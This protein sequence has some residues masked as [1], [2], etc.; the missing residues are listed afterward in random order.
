M[1]AEEIV[2]ASRNGE[3]VP[4]EK[5]LKVYLRKWDRKYGATYK[6]LELLQNIF[7]ETMQPAV[8]SVCIQ[9]V[10]QLTSNYLYK[11]VVTMNPWQQQSSPFDR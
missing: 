9:D 4:T 2:A 11:R 1:C 6:V 10:Q 8:S 5:D 7:Y 3:R